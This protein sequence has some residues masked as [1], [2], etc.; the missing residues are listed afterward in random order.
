MSAVAP[1]FA[2]QETADA[3]EAD[4]LQ[5][6]LAAHGPV[7]VTVYFA[8]WCHDSIRELPRL[9]ALIE[10]QTTRQLRLTLINLDQNKRDPAGR[11]AAAGVSRT[12]TI[13]VSRNGQELGRIV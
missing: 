11:A 13:I 2:R 7:E 8:D 3:D 12:P 5:A 4:A 6:A 10:P 9:L 1:A